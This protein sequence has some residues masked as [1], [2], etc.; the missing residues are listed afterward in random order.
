MAIVLIPLKLKKF[1]KS[2]NMGEI[3]PEN[4]TKTA[5]IS[6]R[7]IFELSNNLVK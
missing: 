6:V 7:S 2:S 1:I 4:G 3:N 5:F